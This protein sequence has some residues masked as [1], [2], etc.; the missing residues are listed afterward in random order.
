MSQDY[1]ERGQLH[2]VV[3][4][5]YCLY[6]Y[7]NGHFHLPSLRLFGVKIGLGAL[8]ILLLTIYFG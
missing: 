1:R 7:F 8:T 3:K 5:N 2:E 4:E 6:L